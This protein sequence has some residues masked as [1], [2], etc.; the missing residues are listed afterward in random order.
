MEEEEATAGSYVVSPPPGKLTSA[1]KKSWGGHLGRQK[2]R[3]ETPPGIPAHQ[4][5]PTPGKCFIVRHRASLA[6]EVIRALSRRAHVG[7]Q[8]AFGPALGGEKKE[9]VIK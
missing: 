1:T 7:H 3:E 2:V 4:Q 9:L 6:A 8:T 5:E